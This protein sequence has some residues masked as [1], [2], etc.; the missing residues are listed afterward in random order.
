MPSTPDQIQGGCRVALRLPEVEREEP[1]EADHGEI[2]GLDALQAV[3]AGHLAA[4]GVGAMR[5]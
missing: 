4:A 2:G 1:D 3:L 5:R